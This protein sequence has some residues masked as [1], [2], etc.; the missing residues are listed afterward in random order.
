MRKAWLKSMVL[1]VG[2]L[3]AGI[4][5][6]SLVEGKDYKLM[7]QPK[8]VEVQGKLEVIEF[9][10]YGC[11]HCYRIEPFVEDWAKKL[12][13]DVNFRR[14]HVVWP[15]RSDIEAHAKIFATLQAMNLDKQYQMAVFNAVQR[16]RIELRREGTL[17]DW[18]K[19]QGIDLA[20]YRAAGFSSNMT[21]KKLEKMSVDYAVDGVPMFVVNGKYVTSPAMLGKED[22]TITRA[23]DELLAA[24]RKKLKK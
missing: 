24:E 18:L 15:G 14:V 20:K 3:A 10:W 19:K 23:I 16:D 8:P 17:N 13:D 1:A 21:L 11:P 4:A 7:A 9:F 2:F 5:H 12:P 6:A 22:G